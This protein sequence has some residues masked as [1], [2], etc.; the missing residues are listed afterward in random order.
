MRQKDDHEFAKL[1][2]RLREGLHTP[3]DITTLKSRIVECNGTMDIESFPHLFTTCFEVVR[4]NEHVYSVC[5]GRSTTTKS[6]DIVTGNL[7]ETY[8]AKGFGKNST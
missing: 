4:F 1:L 5:N 7:Q 3:D 2:N 6:I 8:H